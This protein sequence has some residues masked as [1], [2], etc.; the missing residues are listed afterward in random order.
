M[1]GD[2]GLCGALS[3]KARAAPPA[4]RGDGGAL[5]VAHCAP[6]PPRW[7]PSE[8]AG[9]VR[10]RKAR[11]RS[12]SPRVAGRSRDGLRLRLPQLLAWAM[13]GAGSSEAEVPARVEPR[14]LRAPSEGE[15]KATCNAQQNTCAQE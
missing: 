5:D 11:G 4:E 2:T 8:A 7:E 3:R 1:R 9:F 14:E 15:T 13:E 6:P 10:T 12:P